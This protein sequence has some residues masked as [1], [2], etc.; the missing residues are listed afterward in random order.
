M[1]AQVTQ[2]PRYLITK[3]GK[4]LTMTCSQNMDHESMYW[5]RQDPGLGLKLIY[6]SINVEII[7]KGDIPDGYTVS[8]KEKKNFPLSLK[9]PSTNQ[10]SLYLCASSVSTVLH[11]QLLS[12][13]KGIAQ[14]QPDSFS[15]GPPDQEEKLPDHQCPPWTVQFQNSE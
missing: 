15:E 11:S 3:T 4:T 12:A 5:Y 8:R 2:T 10:T 1:E 14:E 7:D 9:S 6:Y 13:Q